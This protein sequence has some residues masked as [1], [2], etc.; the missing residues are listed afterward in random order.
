MKKQIQKIVSVVAILV[1]LP[2][3]AQCYALRVRPCGSCTLTGLAGVS[4]AV[5]VSCTDPGDTYVSYKTAASGQV[6]LQDVEWNCTYSC[7]GVDASGNITKPL[8]GSSPSDCDFPVSTFSPVGA[9]CN[10]G[11]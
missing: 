7:L 10:S 3:F 4:P 11:G 8:P 6:G 5:L 1:A 2:V 9:N